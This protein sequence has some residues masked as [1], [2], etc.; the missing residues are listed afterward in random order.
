MTTAIG[1]SILTVDLTAV[2]ANFHEL[3]N[4]ARPAECGAVVKADAYGLGAGVV[5]RA[6]FSAGCRTFFVATIEEASAFRKDSGLDAASRLFVL[7]GIDLGD[8]G[9]AANLG[10]IPVLNDLDAVKGWAAVARRS[11]HRIGVALH[12]DTGMNRLGLSQGDTA[13]LIADPTDLAALEIELVLSHLA[14]SEEN[15]NPLNR[16]QRE[17]FVMWLRGLPQARASLANSSGIFL[18][19][20]YHFDLV[21]P[22]VALYGV[23]PLPDRPNPMR[24][25]VQIKGKIVQV[26]DVDRGETVGYGAAHIATRPTRIAT[27]AVGYADGFPRA[28]SN[29]GYGYLAK[30][31]VPLVGRV[32]MDLTTFDV[33]DAAPVDAIP[34]NYIDVLGGLLPIDELAH[35]AG[36][37]GYEI[38][39]RLGRRYRRVYRGT[40]RDA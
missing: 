37:I 36:T 19:P 18:G 35:A 21:R 22:G 34:G 29:R 26:R 11:G 13:A 17:R 27:V 6:L 3:A 14:C 33:T 4:R 40:E 25:V 32:S 9:A 5:A 20:E 24:E 31:R 1:G 39:T 30:A 7:N 16:T 23:N 38:L 2:A 8:A 12:L 10:A 15:A 28:L